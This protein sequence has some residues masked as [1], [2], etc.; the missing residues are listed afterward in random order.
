MGPLK[1]EI[2]I[3]TGYWNK[4]ILPMTLQIQ[5]FQKISFPS[6]DVLI[7]CDQGLST[8]LLSV[9]D[10]ATYILQADLLSLVPKS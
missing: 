3:N 7:F 8:P 4:I 2:I 6:L 9:R 10:P 5:L 1:L